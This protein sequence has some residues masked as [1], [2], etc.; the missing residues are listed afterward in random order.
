LCALR[1]PATFPLRPT[2]GRQ[3]TLRD[4][5]TGAA[6]ISGPNGGWGIEPRMLGLVPRPP[7]RQLCRF[8]RLPT[9]ATRR[10]R[11]RTARLS[12][13]SSAIVF[14]IR[15]PGQLGWPQRDRTTVISFLGSPTKPVSTHWPA[16]RA[17]SAMPGT[18]SC[19][20]SG[21]RCRDR[22]QLQI[23]QHCGW[24]AR[25]LDRRSNPRG[26]RGR[27]GL[28]Y[29]FAANWSAALEYDHLFMGTKAVSFTDPTRH[30]RRNDNIR[31][32]VD[33][34]TVHVN[35]P[36]GWPGDLEVLMFSLS[37]TRLS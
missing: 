22:Q 27:A 19:S 25:R 29:G 2:P 30:A 6:P 23:L 26:R 17:R 5:R 9:H 8:G 31:Q 15:R 28:E 11:R 21:R 20:T 1:S 37:L 4:L 10:H 12:L 3:C 14:G 24:R 33:M 32:D 13:Q 34:V 16:H 35:L 7:G 36:L 18:T